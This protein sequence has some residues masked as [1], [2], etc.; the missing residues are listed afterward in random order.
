[1]LQNA[2]IKL[3]HVTIPLNNL[4]QSPLDF[5]GTDGND[6]AWTRVVGIM[7]GISV[8]LCF[9]LILVT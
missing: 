1:M 7:I 9:N 3:S 8:F 2:I 5:G 4:R 6:T